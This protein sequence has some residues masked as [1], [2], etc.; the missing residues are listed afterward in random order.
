MVFKSQT[1]LNRIVVRSITEF[2]KSKHSS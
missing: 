1:K 2:K